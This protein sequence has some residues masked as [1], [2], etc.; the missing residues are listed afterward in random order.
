[1]PTSEEWDDLIWEKAQAAKSARS[2]DKSIEERSI[3]E[4]LAAR[5]QGVTSDAASTAS[6]GLRFSKLIPPAGGGD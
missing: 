5:N 1:M 3:E 4:L 6:R 2:L